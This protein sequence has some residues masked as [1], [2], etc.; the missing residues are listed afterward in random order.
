MDYDQ[1]IR[2]ASNGY[3]EEYLKLRPILLDVMK[4]DIMEYLNIKEEFDLLDESKKKTISDME[5]AIQRDSKVIVKEINLKEELEED[6]YHDNVWAIHKDMSIEDAYNWNDSMLN[7]PEDDWDPLEPGK[8][9][10]K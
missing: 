5:D 3:I 8:Q 10:L 4:T 7:D 2:T 6:P 1:Y 9:K